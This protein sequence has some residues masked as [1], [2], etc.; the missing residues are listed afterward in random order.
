M[1]IHAIHAF[2]PGVAVEGVE[3]RLEAALE[4]AGR[5]VLARHEYPVGP[6]GPAW[7]E[8]ALHWEVIELFDHGGT[9][10]RTYEVHGPRW[11][12]CLLRALSAITD[13]FVVG[14]ESDR[15][16]EHYALGAMFAG[17]T[18]E[19]MVWDIAFPPPTPPGIGHPPE[20]ERQPGWEVAE[21]KYEHWFQLLCDVWWEGQ[22][23]RS[24][25]LA[26]GEWEV[27]AAVDGYPV[28]DETATTRVVLAHVSDEQVLD[29]LPRM[30]AHGWRWRSFITPKL[31]A[32]MI[33]LAREG[34]L[35][36]SQVA[37][38]G[39]ILECSYAG[40][41]VPGSGEPPR[42]IEGYRDTVDRQLHSPGLETLLLP[43]G[44]FGSVLGETPGL[45]FGRGDT[46]WHRI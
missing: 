33:E 32:P 39:R 12:P 8:G 44:Q 2:A 5:Q 17:R 15:G 18:L 26:A 38:W 7:R 28:D 24:Q 23:W 46:G 29:A 40:F 13:G 45:M 19:T 14:L 41:E 42:T 35:D 27:S 36:P 22:P 31:A 3:R 16:R 34:S 6:K 25:V 11:D 21:T 37:A 43:L 10:L 20:Y 4:R 30:D 9:V 1:G